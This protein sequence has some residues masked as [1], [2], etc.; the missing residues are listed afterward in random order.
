MTESA[1]IAFVE[2]RDGKEAA[3]AWALRICRVYRAS[4]LLNGRN[5]RKFHFASTPTYKRPFIE[6]YL[7]LKRYALRGV[8]Q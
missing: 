2:S 3:R 4:V 8:A 1:R 5:G 7:A 6:S